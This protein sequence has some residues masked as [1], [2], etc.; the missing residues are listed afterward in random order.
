MGCGSSKNI[1]IAE[2]AAV[3]RR[4]PK[5]VKE[6]PDVRSADVEVVERSTKVLTSLLATRDRRYLVDK[7]GKKVSEKYA[8]RLANCCRCQ[9]I[10]VIVQSFVEITAGVS[11]AL[12][13]H[14]CSPCIL[15]GHNTCDSFICLPAAALVFPPLYGLS[16]WIWK[17]VIGKKISSSLKNMCE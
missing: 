11:A 7:S 13:P 6:G 9:V 8:Q 5:A 16:C 12:W 10:G 2:D 3:E 4:N 14:R 17:E 1:T 15:L